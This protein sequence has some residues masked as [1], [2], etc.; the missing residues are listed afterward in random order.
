MRRQ[1][2]A[3]LIIRTVLLGAA[4]CV[5]P[6][7]HADRTGGLWM[8]LGD[9]DKLESGIKPNRVGAKKVPGTIDWSKQR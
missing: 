3:K 4:L 5:T 7:A 9:G 1:F 2:V 6:T 8:L